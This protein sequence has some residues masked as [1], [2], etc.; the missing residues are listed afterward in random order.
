[1]RNRFK[2]KL[3]FVFVL[4]AIIGSS[5]LYLNNNQFKNKNNLVAIDYSEDAN[6]KVIFDASSGSLSGFNTYGYTKLRDG[7][8]GVNDVNSQPE[9]V[10]FS[11]RN[12]HN[13]MYWSLDAACSSKDLQVGENFDLS[14]R[15]VYYACYEEDGFD[16]DGIRYPQ[17][18]SY[19]SGAIVE[20]GDQI[21][22]TSCYVKFGGSARDLGFKEYCDFDKIKRT[23]SDSF[24]EGY[25][26]VYRNRLNKAPVQNCKQKYTA[27]FHEHSFQNGEEIFGDQLEC[28]ST[29]YVENGVC[30]S[31]GNAGDKVKTP[32][33]SN[34][35]FYGRKFIGWAADDDGV[36]VNCSGSLVTDYDVVINSDV[37][38]YACFENKQESCTSSSKITDAVGTNDVKVCYNSV[39][40]SSGNYVLNAI[41]GDYGELISC[42][43]GYVLDN[44]SSTNVTVDTCNKEGI[45]YKNY[46]LTCKSQ[47][48]PKITSITNG[49]VR[50]DGYGLIEFSAYSDVGIKGYYASSFYEQPTVNSGWIFDP[51]GSYSINSTPGLVF[52][53]VIDNNNSISYSA[54]GSVLDTVNSDTTLSSLEIKTS[55][56]D[57]LNPELISDAFVSDTINSSNYVRLSNSLVKDSKILASGFNPFETGYKITTNS[58]SITVYATLTSNDSHYVSGFE[59][60]TVDLDYGINTILIK[61]QDKNG[62]VRTYT[63][64]VTRNDDRDS[65]NTLKSITLSSGKIKFDPYKTEYIVNVGK[66]KKSVSVDGVLSSKSSQFVDGFGP[67]KVELK[68]ERTEVLL[69][70]QSQTGTIRAYSI[71]FVKTDKNEEEGG[72]A[73]LSSLSLSKAYIAF[74]S[75]VFEYNTTVEYEVDSL[76]IYALALNGGDAVTIYKNNQGVEEI[77]NPSNVELSPGYNN[78]II[79]VSSKS[80]KVNKYYLNILRNETGLDVSSETKLSMLSIDGYDIKFNPDKLNYEVKIKS[81]KTLVIAATPQSNRSEIFIKGNDNLTAFS[82]VRLK[83]V[84][85]DGQSREYIIDIQKDKFNKKIETIGLISGV[86]IIL[87]GIL[88]IGIKK[89]RKSINDYYAE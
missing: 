13:I 55:N 8:Y 26:T 34:L 50:S 65:T 44:I 7:V 79:K 86:G 51:R 54:M 69:K 14:T 18:N 32:N 73:L 48:R 28:G 87:C 25:G 4:V 77:V 45:C 82:T 57:T 70:V 5:F 64:L 23:D 12:G 21:H 42:R 9:S 1:M 27:Y 53:W 62:K 39:K 84:A 33:S 78:F 74:N 52:L 24:V 19:V 66:N 72:E 85:E 15:K 67:R 58:S 68:N 80:G 47:E 37:H 36:D 46:R 75:E 38:Y 17:E 6:Y 22:V 63:I 30:K 35:N 43:S 76:D 41:S 16:N 20:C 89:R 61:I 60:R 29:E 40:N 56:G 10:T 81:E 71:I 3:M 49:T 88:F 11:E 83:V 31:V 59:P 2:K